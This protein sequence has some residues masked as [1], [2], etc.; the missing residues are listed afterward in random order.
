[1]LT[2]MRMTLTDNRNDGG[3]GSGSSNFSD[4][5]GIQDVGAPHKT[6]DVD[7]IADTVLEEDIVAHTVRLTM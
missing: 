7:D 1:M 6:I 3:G 4:S 5:F 2:M